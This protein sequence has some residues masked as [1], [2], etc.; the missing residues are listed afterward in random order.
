MRPAVR[1]FDP[2]SALPRVRRVAAAFAQRLRAKLAGLRQL[3]LPAARAAVFV[4]KTW[5]MQNRPCA[6]L[7]NS[8]G[9]L[10]ELGGIRAFKNPVK[11]CVFTIIVTYSD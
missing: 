3:P 6:N 1:I 11:Y 9:N 8:R 7:A 2:A 10:L 5:L 4:N